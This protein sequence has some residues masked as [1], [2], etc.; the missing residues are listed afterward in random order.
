MSTEHADDLHYL[1][2][3]MLACVMSG[4]IYLLSPILTPFLL[5][6]VIAYICNPM[7]AFLAGKKLSRTV[8]AVLVMFFFARSVCSLDFDPGASIRGRSEAVIE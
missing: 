7:V 5:A 1:W 8:G 6:A 2:W 3:L 4:L